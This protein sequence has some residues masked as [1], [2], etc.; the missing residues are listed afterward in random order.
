[1]SGQF[2]PFP[3]ER[4][5][6]WIFREF[7]ERESILDIQKELFFLPSAADPFRLKRGPDMLATPFG[8]AAGPHTQLAGG[9]LASWI[10]GA[11]CL[12][13]KTVQ[14]VGVEVARPCIRMRDEGLNVEFS[15]E[16][17]P[18]ESFQQYLDAWILIHA[19]HNHLNFFGEGPET[20]CD[21]SV[22][23]QLEGLKK[24]SM[25]RY[26][27]LV[28][29]AGAML[30]SRRARLEKL[31][32]SAVNL[33][34]PSRLA[35]RATLSTLHGC[36]PEE[37]GAML[38][39]LM[40]EQDFDVQVKLNPSLLGAGFVRHILHEKLGF[41][42]LE[43]D[44]KAFASDLKVDEAVDLISE[45][46]SVAAGAGHSFGIKLSNTLPLC[47]HGDI[48][49]AAEKS[50]YLSGR[51]LH[52]LTVQIA[53]E[54][55]RRCGADLE[56]SFCGGVDAFNAPALLACGMT[57]I[58]T[59][60][61]LLRPGGIPRLGQYLEESAL[62]MGE[63]SSIEDFV[64][65]RARSAGFKG[66][67]LKKAAQHNLENY[68]AQVLKNPVYQR[69]HYHRTGASGSRSLGFFDCIE[70]PC[71]SS[72]GIGQQVPEYLR[73]IASDDL[74]GAAAVIRQDNPL[75]VI[76]GRTCH[77]PC[78][79]TCLRSHYDKPLAIRDLK[80]FALENGV[81]P[82]LPKKNAGTGTTVAI[83]GG[84]P[85]GLAAAWELRL[86]GLPVTIFEA[87]R[88]A[89]GM[90]HATIPV[91]RAAEEAVQTDLDD[92]EKLGVVFRYNM[93][94][95]REFSLDNLREAG[96]GPIILATGAPRGRPLGLDGEKSEGVSDGLSFLR[97]F[98]IGQ[99]PDLQGLSVGIIG[100]G[101]VAMDCARSAVRLGAKTQII[102][103]RRKIDAPAHPE[104]IRALSEE[105]IGFSELLAPE[106]LEFQDSRLSALRCRP[107]KVGEIGPDGRPRPVPLLGESLRIP[108]DL[109]IVAIGQKPD[110]AVATINDLQLSPSGWV[111][112]DPDTGRT[113]V[114]G[115]WAGGD[116]VRGP[117][118][119][120]DAA[121][122]GRKIAA[123]ILKS[124][125]L[126]ARGSIR[127]PPREDRR[128]EILKKRARRRRRIPTPELSPA[129]RDSFAE[130]LQTMAPA[131]ARAEASRCLDCDLLCSTCVTVC[132]NRAFMTLSLDPFSVEWP[133]GR[134]SDR[135]IRVETRQDHQVALLADWCNACGNCT[136]FCPTADRPHSAKP[137]ITVNSAVFLSSKEEIFLPRLEC[138]IFELRFHRRGEIH[139]MRFEERLFY[140]G[141]G[142]SACLNRESAE[143]Q[144][145]ACLPGASE[146]LDWSACH[147]LLTLGRAILKS[148]PDLLVILEE[149]ERASAG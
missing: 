45:M 98:R 66:P 97:H 65:Y 124:L 68:A 142:F 12:E 61:D 2:H 148:R 16:L 70:A 11:R 127:R 118:S 71:I 69:E 50:M 105:G 96:Y 106:E 87:G 27:S 140:T 9:I 119:I 149:Q 28:R 125:G 21:I 15:Q 141:A 135:M 58:T 144:E 33:Q 54:L 99:G 133:A 4:L 63:A 76:L 108:L 41:L 112:A 139:A 10:C 85:C 136:E 94:F 32:P 31:R 60:S 38:R 56:I 53:A 109:L 49:P 95:G 107:M 46:R 146:T 100:A 75:P 18:E 44:D 3:F 91:Y 82:P 20:S 52:P 80:R 17:N 35:H 43:P 30:D 37:I 24:A 59:C 1:M 79:N 81:T 83:I 42:D 128:L 14:S 13:L 123:D 84:G 115:F 126:P 34:I 22:G 23:Y 72:C 78:E 132:P 116:A 51:P 147:A 6:A 77:H 64:L 102:Y 138:G 5:A 121:G 47:H 129:Q 7:C 19:L 117:S 145:F 110:P 29:D 74:E 93:R 104:E 143:V 67:E 92:I 131:D 86:R 122:D 57:P 73:R 25:L 137:R 89:G 36:P 113:S 103:R 120:V 39:Y 114:E 55:R 134:A 130:V 101:D 62:V 90:V 48:F 8:V 26:F 40:L 111:L 88:S